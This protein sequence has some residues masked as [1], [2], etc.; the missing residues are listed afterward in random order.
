MS[1]PVVRT[2]T[3]SGT[4]QGLVWCIYADGRAPLWGRSQAALD[5]ALASLAAVSLDQERGLALPDLN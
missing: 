1:A 2:W 5:E 4:P 3:G